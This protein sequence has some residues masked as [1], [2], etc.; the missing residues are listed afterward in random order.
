M[1]PKAPTLSKGDATRTAILHQAL[2]L[3]SELGFEGLTIGVLAGKVGMSKSGLYAHFS[4]KEDLQCAALDA[5]A[6]RFLEVV[7]RQ[8]LTAP[9]GLPRLERLLT[10]WMHWERDEFAGGCPFIVAASE[11][12]DRPGVVRTKLAEY[13]NTMIVFIDKAAQIAVEE[14]HFRPDLDPRQYAFEFWGSMLAYQQFLRLLEADDAERLLH[15]A[16]AQL[17][18]RASA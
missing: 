18:A 2:E 16:M 9:R 13:F 3:S 14:G 1:N 5:A 4:S 6:D 17:N 11:F 7:A 15:S 8:A 12:D 10:Q